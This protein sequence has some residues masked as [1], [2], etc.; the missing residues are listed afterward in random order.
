MQ[1]TYPVI[2]LSFAAVKAGNLEDAKTQ[3]K[4]EIA[5]LYEENRYLLEKNILS[6]NEQK[7]YNNTT[8]EMDDTTAQKALNFT[9]GNN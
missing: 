5:D 4:Q 8:E 7:I 2:F 3:I 1:G 6:D 9:K